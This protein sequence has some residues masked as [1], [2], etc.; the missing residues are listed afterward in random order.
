MAL[1]DP[2]TPPCAA[3][4]SA[5]DGN[6]AAPAAVAGPGSEASTSAGTVQTQPDSVFT[7][8]SIT[9][10]KGGGA[11]RGIAEKFTAN[12]VARTG[13][14]TI[15]I[16]TSPDCSGFGPTLTLNY[17]PEQGNGPFGLTEM[18]LFANKFAWNG[19]PPWLDE[20]ARPGQ[21]LLLPI[22]S[23]RL[24]ASASTAVESSGAFPVMVA[25]VGPGAE[26]RSPR[27]DDQS[28]GIGATWRSH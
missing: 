28:H 19:A 10:P 15:P 1:T 18:V 3:T 12:P 13:S 7:P 17:D 16:A 22:P 24:T 25:A 9:L 14:F 4:P 11:I 6:L 23:G 8:P 2:A 20:P 5:G 26:R 21:S 27:A